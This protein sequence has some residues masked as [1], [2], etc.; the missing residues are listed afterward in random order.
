MSKYDKQII[1]FLLALL[2]ILTGLVMVVVTEQWQW[3][4]ICFLFA[5]A[6][7]WGDS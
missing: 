4:L 7:L 5:P 3:W 6:L 2:F 1:G